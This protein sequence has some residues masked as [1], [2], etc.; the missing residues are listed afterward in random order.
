MISLKRKIKKFNFTF[1]FKKTLLIFF[2]FSESFSQSINT[3][4][5]LLDN[6]KKPFW[7][8]SNNNGVYSKGSIVK[9]KISEELRTLNYGGEIIFPL[10]QIEKP[11]FNQ[12]YLGL[13][14]NNYYFQIGKKSNHAKHNYLSSGSLVERAHAL[15]L[16]KILISL[17]Q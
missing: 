15:P 12:A 10:N 3:E 4:T 7:I 11:L 13:S 9:F 16:S 14:S 2:L 8:S 5:H 1:F 17:T 6:K